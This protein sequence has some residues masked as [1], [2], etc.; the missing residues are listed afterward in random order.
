MSCKNLLKVNRT[1]KT[2]EGTRDE[3]VT[4]FEWRIQTENTFYCARKSTGG[5]PLV[6]F[7]PLRGNTLSWKSLP[8]ILSEPVTFRLSSVVLCMT[9]LIETAV[10][11]S[12]RT[13]K[14]RRRFNQIQT[15]S[16]FMMELQ[17]IWKNGV[18]T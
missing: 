5:F 2:L 8:H 14:I 9:L 6:L 18:M 11:I 13:W 12:S 1:N 7:W 10:P 17:S 15:G 4:S 3:L 16:I